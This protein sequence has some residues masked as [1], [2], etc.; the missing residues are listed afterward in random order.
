MSYQPTATPYRLFNDHHSW[1]EFKNLR[2]HHLQ[3]K[4]WLYR[5]FGGR[6]V[7]NACAGGL[8]DIQNWLDAGFASVLAI[9]KDKGQIDTARSRLTDLDT[10]LEASELEINLVEGDLTTPMIIDGGPF[11][12]VFCH[13]AIHYCWTTAD[14]IRIFISNLSSGL[15]NNGRIVITYLRGEILLREK[16]I[17]IFNQHGELE[18]S[19][20]VFEPDSSIADVFVA[21]IGVRHSESVMLLD[22]IIS[23]F[24]KEAGLSYVASFPFKTFA[25]ILPSGHLLSPM[26]LEM[27]SLYA[28]AV[29]EKSQPKMETQNLFFSVLFPP[30]LE[31]EVLSFLDIPDLVKGRLVSRFWKNE[32]DHFQPPADTKAAFFDQPRLKLEYDPSTQEY[33]RG[34]L[35]ISPPA[36]AMFL[37]WGGTVSMKKIDLRSNPIIWDISDDDFD[38][39][40][41]RR[42]Y[43]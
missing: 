24:K 9:D 5:A 17:K 6:K 3:I 25:N 39:N 22:E 11:V 36:L 12:A 30:K 7:I 4:G 43:Q 28:V 42:L 32:I 40:F 34:S 23:H 41:E 15:G 16:S 10:A 13:F 27:S 33:A 20:D 29:F 14:T 21:S 18:F 37:R 38:Y 19:A 31:Y 2:I 26:E 8:S 1:S 35:L